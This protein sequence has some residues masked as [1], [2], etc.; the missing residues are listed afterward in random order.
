MAFFTEIGILFTGMTVPAL[1]ALILGF[2]FVV[3]EIFQPGFGIFGIVGGI[4][5]TL[6]IVLRAL[7]GDGNVFAQVF[8]LIFF[9]AVGILIAF[10]VLILTAKKGWLNR[11]PLV[12]SGTAVAVT[13]SEGTADYSDLI[14]STGVATTDLKPVG[15]ALIGDKT[16]EVVSDG[17]YIGKGEN[18]KVVAVEGA[19]ISVE[20]AE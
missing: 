13:R 5:I 6:G 20:R 15:K 14:G 9:E 19:K 2:V 11:S 16:V 3:I 1:I 8:L 12:E 4:L 17:F 18:V 10:L 7:V